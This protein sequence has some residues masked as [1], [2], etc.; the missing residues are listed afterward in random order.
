MADLGER[1]DALRRLAARQDDV[2]TT[3]QCLELGLSD[4]WVRRRVQSA[5]WQSLHLGVHVVH[6]G[7][8]P[9]RT[10]ARAGLLHAGE[11]AALSHRSAGAL[12]GLVLER[13][14]VIEVSIPHRRRVEP[15]E[16]VRVERRR[17]MP[18][19]TGRLRTVTRPETVVDL[20]GVMATDDAVVALLV[21]AVRAGT[22]PDEVLRALA[23]RPSAR[24]RRLAVELLAEVAEGVE[25][26]L[27][28]RYRR[29]VER[30]HGLPHARLQVRE[31]LD[32]GWIRADCRYVGLG[33][34]VELDGRLAHPGGRTDDDT[35]RDNAVLLSSGDLTLRYRWSHVRLTPC[36]T[37]TQ[38]AAA[39]R[40]HGWQG[41]PR[42]CTPTCPVP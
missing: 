37:A 9:W 42:R 31:R 30:R 34:R 17:V 26:P 39:L 7:P 3:A 28:L 21:A 11:G 5:R 13:P 40:A 33:V 15:S 22:T 2:V 14:R 38:V 24:R 6:S 27:E 20:L 16:G 10:R 8:V 19:S 4:G 36:R 29:D 1:V 18:P 23:G 12:H 41:R 32:G 25:S 35:W